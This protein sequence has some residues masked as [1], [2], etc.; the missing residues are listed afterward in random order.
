MRVKRQ[1]LPPPFIAHIILV[2]IRDILQGQHSRAE[3]YWCV[4]PESLREWEGLLVDS[5]YCVAV[6]RVDI[7]FIDLV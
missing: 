1:Q 5:G 4:V 2:L 6:L 7:I 3:A